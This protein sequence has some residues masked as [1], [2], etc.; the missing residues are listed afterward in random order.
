LIADPLI[1]SHHSLW[2][3]TTERCLNLRGVVGRIG[4]A[5]HDD[6]DFAP[7]RVLIRQ[8]REH[9]RILVRSYNYITEEAHEKAIS[10]TR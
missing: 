4:G 2:Q 3:N 10:T 1:Y 5:C 6:F 9:L 7:N 8:I